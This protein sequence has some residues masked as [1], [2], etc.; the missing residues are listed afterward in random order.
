MYSGMAGGGGVNAGQMYRVNE[1]RQEYFKP[2]MS[3]EVIPI[4]GSGNGGG[5]NGITVVLQP[6]IM[7]GDRS[8]I[9][10]VLLPAI[11]EGVRKA[12]ADGII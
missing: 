6:T 7:T 12:K 10:N 5:G 2:S 1:T 9:N 4:G 3:G 8:S 11:I